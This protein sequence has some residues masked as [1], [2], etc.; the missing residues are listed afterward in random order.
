VSFGKNLN[1]ALVLAIEKRRSERDPRWMKS[2]AV[3]S[4]AFVREVQE[5]LERRRT[6]MR[7]TGGVWTL[8]ETPG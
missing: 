4:E 3:V 6:A 8:R 2:R 1:A 5:R 7:E